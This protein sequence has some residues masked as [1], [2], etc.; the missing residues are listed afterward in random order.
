MVVE[1][2]SQLKILIV[3]LGFFY[4]NE[5]DHLPCTVS[6]QIAPNT[7][8]SLHRFTPTDTNLIVG[9]KTDGSGDDVPGVS[10]PVGDIVLH[11]LLHGLSYLGHLHELS[12]AR[13]SVVIHLLCTLRASRTRRHG[14]SSLVTARN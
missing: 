6:A 12:Q 9:V 4:S 3:K 13:D 10:G 7:W 2:L 1:S 11:P 14:S 5:E 8:S